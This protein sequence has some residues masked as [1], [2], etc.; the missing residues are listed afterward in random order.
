MLSF[1]G[2]PLTAGFIGKL[3]VFA[4]A[5]AGGYGWLVLVA[6]VMSVIAAVF[7]LKVIVVMWFRGEDPEVVGTVETPSLWTWS[8][9]IIA[10]V[11]TLV[12]GLIPGG[13]LE[14]FGSAAQF[15]R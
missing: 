3:A 14:L 9:L 5:W 6:V 11:A 12:L 7:Y 15:I 8:V 10:A 2:I 13:L 4:A 1:A